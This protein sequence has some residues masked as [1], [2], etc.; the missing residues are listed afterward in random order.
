M[1]GPLRQS[2]RKAFVRTLYERFYDRF[3]KREFLFVT[4]LDG[5]PRML[6]ERFTKAL[7]TLYERFTKALRTLYER[8]TNALA[9]GPKH[10][11]ETCHEPRGGE[12][13]PLREPAP[14]TSSSSPRGLKARAAPSR[15]ALRA[16]AQGPL[17]R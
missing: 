14:E 10:A 16:T 6:Y 2:V 13:L 15:C 11:P 8:F 9:Q 12:L 7:R 1:P 4:V 17:N 5:Y 3:T